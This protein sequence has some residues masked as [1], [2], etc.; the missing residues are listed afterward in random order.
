M[1]RMKKLISFRQL[2]KN[3]GW[4]LLGTGWQCH[5]SGSNEWG[6]ADEAL[7][8]CCARVCPVWKRLN[9]ATGGE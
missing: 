9:N 5:Y 6:H 2:S 8:K 4:A 7:G 3:C 1:S